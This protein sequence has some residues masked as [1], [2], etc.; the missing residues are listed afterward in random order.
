M[1]HCESYSN[2]FSPS[3]KQVFPQMTYYHSSTDLSPTAWVTI[4]DFSNRYFLKIALKQVNVLHFEFMKIKK[5][6]SDKSDTLHEIKN[7]HM[8]LD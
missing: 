2:C 8:C 4:L 5:V 3:R 1:T 7:F 6:T